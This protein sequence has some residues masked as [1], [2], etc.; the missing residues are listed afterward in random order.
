MKNRVIITTVFGA[1]VLAGCGSKQDVNEKNFSMAIS[2]YLDKKGE[3]CLQLNKWPIDVTEMDLRLQKT[4]PTGTAGRMEA[5]AAIGLASGVD[6]EVDQIDMF[7]NKPTGHKFKVKRYSLTDAGKKFYREKEVNQIGL[8]GAKKFM[9]GDVCYGK[10]ALDKIVK[11]EGPMKFGDYQEANVEYL[12]KIENLADWT[13]KPEFQIA[14][15]YIAQIVNG[16]G[17]QELQ[18]GVKLT[19]LGWESKGLD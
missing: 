14:F 13:K 1:L 9:Q 4:M 19:S 6:T 16:A 7:D 2:Q 18:G 5:L 3:L 17:K 15:P 8:G 10:K 12:Y 11:W